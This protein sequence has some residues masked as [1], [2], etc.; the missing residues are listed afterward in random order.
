MEN[1][2]IVTELSWQRKKDIRLLYVSVGYARFDPKETI[3]KSKKRRKSG[4]ND[5]I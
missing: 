4:G 5:S 1:M 2:D 3:I